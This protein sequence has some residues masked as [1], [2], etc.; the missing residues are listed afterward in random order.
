[1]YA[2]LSCR[3]THDSGV[4]QLPR[5]VLGRV[6]VPHKMI[7]AVRQFHAGI[8]ARVWADDGDSSD[9]FEIEGGLR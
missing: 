8:R 1:M 6:G 7:A 3:K 2:S 4:K 5:E 9:R